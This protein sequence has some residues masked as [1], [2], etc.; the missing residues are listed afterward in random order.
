MNE[1]D[2]SVFKF[3]QSS[4]FSH[5]LMERV[6][7]HTYSLTSKR[8]FVARSNI[9]SHL[10]N[11]K[12]FIINIDRHHCSLGILSFFLF[13]FSYSSQI[14]FLRTS[15]NE[16]DTVLCAFIIHPDLCQYWKHA[17]SNETE[18]LSSNGIH[19]SLWIFARLLKEWRRKICKL[20]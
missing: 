11:R 8:R 19:L 14:Q 17:I 12:S 5:G 4:Q 15:T 6:R 1:I 9:H 7:A 3:S 2:V 10:I 20:N 16:H 18:N 13:S